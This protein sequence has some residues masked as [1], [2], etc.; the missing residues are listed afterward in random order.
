RDRR[1]ADASSP[2]ATNEYQSFY[3]KLRSE[4]DAIN[5]AYAEARRNFAERHLG[6]ALQICHDFLARYPGHA[7]FRA[8][9]FDIEE[10]QRQQLSAVIADV[11][12]RL[13][14]EMDLD[15]KVSLVH[16]ALIEYP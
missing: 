6:R 7:L 8:L 9:A 11:D 12:R 16:E 3:D 2:D 1:G 10:Q 5:S 4:H 14:S 13:D 15:A